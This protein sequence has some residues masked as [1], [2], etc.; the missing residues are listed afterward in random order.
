MLKKMIGLAAVL[1]AV[2]AVPALA[3]PCSPPVV[4]YGVEQVVVPPPQPR[5]YVNQGP[6]FT[7][8]DTYAPEPVYQE[9]GVTG[10]YPYVSSYPVPYSGGPYADPYN[11]YSYGGTTLQGPVVYGHPHYHYAAPVYR[12]HAARHYYRPHYAVRAPHYVGPRYHTSHVYRGVTRYGAV[13]P[14]YQRPVAPAPR[15]MN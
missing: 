9:H 12:Y 8:P 6:T 10:Y 11:H 5:Y 14:R 4:G 13:A 3:C 15:Y 7:G 2:S 1:V